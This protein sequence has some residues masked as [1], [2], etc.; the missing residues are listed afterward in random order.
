MTQR[1]RE[2]KGE[3]EAGEHIEKNKKEENVMRVE[4]Y[5]I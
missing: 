3:K 5:Y 2:T 1:V 4:K